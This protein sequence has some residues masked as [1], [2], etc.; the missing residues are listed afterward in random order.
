MLALSGGGDSAALALILADPARQS[1]RSFHALI[2]DHRLRPESRAE[3]ELAAERAEALGARARILV[4]DSPQP[5]QAAARSARH[6]LLAE[7]CQD[8]GAERLFLAH[9]ADDVIETMIM[10]LT[11]QQARW[12]AL[13]AMGEMAMSPAWPEGRGLRIVRPLVRTSRT[14]LREFLVGQGASWIE[15]PSNA[16]TRFERVRV[17]L[18]AP[19]PGTPAG[20]ALLTLNEGALALDHKVRV[21]AI[22]LIGRAAHLH[23]WGAM[24]L[25]AAAFARAPELVARRALEAATAAVSGEGALPRRAVVDTM[26]TALIGGGAASGGGALLTS[27]GVLGR[28]PGAS[29]G[30]ADG[31]GGAKALSLSP[32]STGVFDGRFL[33]CAGSQ[34]L[35]VSAAGTEKTHAGAVPPVLRASLVRVQAGD[36]PMIAG[37]DDIAGDG[38]CGSMIADRIAHVLYA[39]NPA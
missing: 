3:A 6:R 35:T 11:R 12:R 34:A 9:T 1:G 25:D 24:T 2:V 30:R 20:A 29:A 17:R 13:A 26:L 7:A 15:D 18:H 23:P 4:W 36:V 27:Q 37:L 28:D 14:R 33:V 21:A 19:L 10:R 22:A 5:G 8:I 16:N 32:G 38:A 39:D 31:Q